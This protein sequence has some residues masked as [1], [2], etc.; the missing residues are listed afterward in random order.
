[1]GASRP[2]GNR[3]EAP[4]GGRPPLTLQHLQHHVHNML[5][6]GISALKAEAVPSEESLAA[7]LTI[8]APAEPAP[9]LS[10][11]LHLVHPSS[12]LGVEP[13]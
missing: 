13:T 11:D 1:M 9:I 2:S 10:R 12:Y 6:T 7:G 4:E 3:G 8:F 5:V